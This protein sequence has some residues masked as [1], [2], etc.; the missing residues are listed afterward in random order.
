MS[1]WLVAQEHDFLELFDFDIVP[2]SY[3]VFLHLFFIVFESIGVHDDNSMTS[4]VGPLNLWQHGSNL[5]VLIDCSLVRPQSCL[6]GGSRNEHK[7]TAS[8][9]FPGLMSIFWGSKEPFVLYNKTCQVDGNHVVSLW[10]E[11]L[12]KL[13]LETHLLFNVLFYFVG[14]D[15]EGLNML[16][17]EFMFELKSNPN[18]SKSGAGLYD[19]VSISLNHLGR[20]FQLDFILKVFCLIDFIKYVLELDV[21]GFEEGLEVFHLA[22]PLNHAYLQFLYSDF[23]ID[24]V[25]EEGNNYEGVVSFL[26]IYV[27]KVHRLDDLDL[28]QI[29]FH[30]LLVHLVLLL[31]KMG[32]VL[33]QATLFHS[34]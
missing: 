32:F 14:D 7:Y 1:S 5:E 15:S 19:E 29:N 22:V 16:V 20:S 24:D 11:E 18:F 25:N 23:P 21:P 3:G 9:F 27:G 26:V 12:L 2:N 17:A 30:F 31:L 34:V 33:R 13:E 10:D 28:S 8:E 6:V 4:S